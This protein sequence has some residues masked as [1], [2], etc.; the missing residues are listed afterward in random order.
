MEKNK[1]M[2]FDDM[3]KVNVNSFTE[4]KGGL[5]YLSWANAWTE[6]KKCY[7]MATY[8]VIKTDEG[9]PYFKDESLGIMCHTE[10]TVPYINDGADLT[11]EMWLPVMDFR[12]K[13]MVNT[14][15][16]FDINKTIMR[17]LV[18]NLAMFGLGLYIYAGEDLP[19]ESKPSIK[20]AVKPSLLDKD[21]DRAIETIKEGKYSSNEL[22][23]RFNLS[24]EQQKTII[25]LKSKKNGK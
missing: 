7:P 17:C 6:F 15:T 23:D 24:P 11:Y 4:K 9:K 13:A 25:N 5:T 22:E 2:S 10:V 8:K 21:F 12:N 3:L 16:M 20:K 1:S 19:E 14:A 18:K